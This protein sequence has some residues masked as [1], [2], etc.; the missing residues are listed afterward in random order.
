MNRKTMFSRL[1]INTIIDMLLLLIFSAI[2]GIGFMIKYVLLT[3]EQKI[4]KFGANFEQTFLGLNRHGWGDI[5]LYLGFI[6]IALLIIHIVF[7]WDM[8]IVMFKKFFD[9]MKL[10]NSVVA[11]FLFVCFALMVLPFFIKPVKGE[12]ENK[13]INKAQNSLVVKKNMEEKAADNHLINKKNDSHEH[14]NVNGLNI[15]GFMSIERVCINHKIP[16]E[17]FK[18]K[19]G[20]PSSF[21]GKTALSIL[22]K[23]HGIKMSEIEKVITD[24]TNKRNFN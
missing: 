18:E 14:R 8:I 13:L 16:M 1:T 12:V 10:K 6:F 3:G 7:H 19:L 2:I 11:V 20:L 5:H 23:R 15:R 17:V 21:S 4:E 9:K 24:Y 22:R